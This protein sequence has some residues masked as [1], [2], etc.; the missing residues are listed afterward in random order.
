MLPRQW[1]ISHVGIKWNFLIIKEKSKAE[2]TLVQTTVKSRDQ[3]WGGPPGPRGSPWT[4]SSLGAS[5]SCITPQADGGVG[6]GPGGP[7]HRHLSDSD[8]SEARM[9]LESST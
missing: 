6:R 9:L 5:G 1:A 4:R 2:S 8:K 7:P 3:R